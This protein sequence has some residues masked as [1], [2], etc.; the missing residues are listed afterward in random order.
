M[1]LLLEDIRFILCN[2]M[3]QH[4]PELTAA[5]QYLV[6]AFSTAAS[7]FGERSDSCKATKMANDLAAQKKVLCELFKRLYL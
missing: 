7:L 2:Q 1:S 6:L 3:V 4:P 5:K